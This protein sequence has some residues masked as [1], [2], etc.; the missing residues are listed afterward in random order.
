MKK[1][2]TAIIGGG[3][4][5]LACAVTCG[6]STVI[7]ER[8]ARVGRKL[9]ATGSGR[10]NITNRNASASHYHGDEALIHSVLSRF[11]PKDCEQFFGQMGVLFRDEEDGRVY[12]YSNQA[13]TVLDALRAACARRKVEELCEF[14]ITDIKKKKGIFEII[15]DRM[16]IQAENVVL[17]TG[18][19]A[20]PSLGG[21]DTGYQLLQPFGIFSTPL[22][23][24]LCPVFTK[25][26]YKLL[27]GVRAKG[28]VT[29]F[30]NG[31]PIL[32]R[33]G[34]IQ[35]TDYGISGI[36]VFETARWAYQPHTSIE[37]DVM[38]DYSEKELCRYLYQCRK[39]FADTSDIL[40]GALHKKLS[41]VI[42]QSCGLAKKPCRDLSE[43]DIQ[44]LAHTVKHFA[45]TPVSGDGYQ[46]AQVTAGGISSKYL[47][48]DTLM[49]KNVKNLYVCGELLDVDGDCGGY[50]L[51]F[52]FGSGIL[53]GK[54]VK[55]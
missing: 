18:S 19:K 25:E 6:G 13:S 26:K 30:S 12:P 54:A 20:S 24:A 44:T 28:S 46:S 48:A 16:T 40:S 47:H 43:R 1:V 7:L 33:D 32:S 5:G 17:A 29:L 42:V 49:A 36:C 3:A 21:N 22:Q 31:K 27:K 9:L 37:I 10:C 55:T 51:H 39:L 4:A 34:E 41:Q 14:A 11:S 35:F 38:K 2:T 50:N 45:F 23:P 15:S 52:A 53:V 8:Q